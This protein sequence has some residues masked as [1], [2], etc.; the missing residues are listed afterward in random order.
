M[1]THQLSITSVVNDHAIG[2][3]ANPLIVGT[4]YGFIPGLIVPIAHKTFQDKKVGWG[5]VA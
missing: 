5:K 2:Q 4:Y 1:Y 3:T